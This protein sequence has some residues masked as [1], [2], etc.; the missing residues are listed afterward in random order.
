MVCITRDYRTRWRELR[1]C[2]ECWGLLIVKL[3]P[4]RPQISRERQLATSPHG[5]SARNRDCICARWSQSKRFNVSPAP[6]VAA[7]RKDRPIRDF[8]DVAP[9]RR[10]DDIP[11]TPPRRAALQ[12]RCQQ[13]FIGTHYLG[14]LPIS[15]TRLITR[16][17]RHQ[18]QKRRS[19]KDRQRPYFSQPPPPI[20]AQKCHLLRPRPMRGRL[21]CGA[22]PPYVAYAPAGD[23]V[24]P[25]SPD[26]RPHPRPILP[27][28]RG[29]FAAYLRFNFPTARPGEGITFCAC[30]TA[31]IVRI[32]SVWL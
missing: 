4:R 10:S 18:A 9:A 20:S 13:H 5:R 2:C 15:H 11:E 24:Q 29:V 12:E 16:R 21:A 17:A 26:V 30:L 8:W 7:F 25:R 28:F 3:N 6:R 32:F 1:T 31:A 19:N 23:V 14:Y 22:S 27:T